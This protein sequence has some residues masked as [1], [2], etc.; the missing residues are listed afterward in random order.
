MRITATMLTPAEVTFILAHQLGPSKGWDDL[1]NDMRQGR[2]GFPGVADLLPIIR[3]R[4]APGRVPTPLY[5]LVDVMA[6]V[7]SVR[8]QL[9][10]AKPFAFKR[11]RFTFDI[12]NLLNPHAGWKYRRGAPALP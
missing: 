7:T 11:R 10:C 9:G 2:A 8:L 12:E 5:R 1:L 3:D 4:P 6:F